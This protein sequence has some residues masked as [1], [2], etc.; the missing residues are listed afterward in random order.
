M[1]E[2]QGGLDLEARVDGQAALYRSRL[3]GC[4]ADTEVTG[5]LSRQSGSTRE[6]LPGS[7]RGTET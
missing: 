2:Q 6:A 1:S 4:P 7:D 5:L 3:V